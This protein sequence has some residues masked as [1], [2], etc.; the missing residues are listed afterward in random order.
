MPFNRPF[1]ILLEDELDEVL[2]HEAEK[3]HADD[4]DDDDTDDDGTDQF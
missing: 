1:D 2:E 4:D 3:S